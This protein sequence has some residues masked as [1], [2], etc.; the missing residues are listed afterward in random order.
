MS[1]STFRGVLVARGGVAN[2]KI[3]WFHQ[4]P[5]GFYMGTYFN[6]LPFHSSYHTDGKRHQIIGDNR[7]PWKYGQRLDKF[8]GWELHSITA[9][10][11]NNIPGSPYKKKKKVDVVETIDIHDYPH[12]T[13]SIIW[14][15][16]EVGRSDLIK[17]VSKSWL[18]GDLFLFNQITPWL[19]VYLVKDEKPLIE[20]DEENIYVSGIANEKGKQYEFIAFG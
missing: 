18:R 20:M 4:T 5:Q 19:V 16:F 17:E 11:K 3:A 10:D 12:D 8:L 2:K 13:I 15:F 7:T 9:F 1:K 14:A 6:N